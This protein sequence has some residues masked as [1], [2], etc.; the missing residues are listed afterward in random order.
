MKA[1][2]SVVQS[3]HKSIFYRKDIIIWQKQ[4][5]VVMDYRTKKL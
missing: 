2:L 3:F 5:R 4:D 1:V